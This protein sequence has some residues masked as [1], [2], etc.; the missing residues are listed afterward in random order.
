[1]F[2][3]Y[4]EM[5]GV[6]CGS[7]SRSVESIAPNENDESESV[8]DYLKK[9][10]KRKRIEDRMGETALSEFERYL[11]ANVEDDEDKTFD[12]LAW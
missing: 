9:K 4:S 5:R 1:M 3:D 12:I 2:K 11:K 6:T 8:E 10:F 7:S